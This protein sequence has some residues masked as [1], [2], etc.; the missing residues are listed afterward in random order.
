MIASRRSFLMGAAA[1]SAAVVTTET[2]RAMAAMQASA[3]WA[4]A[5]A[6]VEADIAPRAMRLVHGRAPAGL[7]GTLFRNGPAKFRRPGGSATHWFDGDGMM[8]AFRINE[9]QVTLDARFA[10]T[11]KRRWESE[12]G[13]VVTP[14]FGTSG[15]ARA[16]VGSND[17]ANAANT[18]VMV[19]GDEIWALWEGGSPLAMSAADLSTKRFVTLRDDL[20]GM[21]F[22]AHPRYD[23][24]GTIWNIGLNGDKAVVWRL[25]ADRSLHT[26]QVIDLPRASFMHDFTATARHLILVLQ[27]WVFDHR[28]MPYASQ[29][30][31]KPELGT[32]IMVV[33][34]A[35]LSRRRLFDLPAFSYFHVGDAWEDV[36]GTIRF[37]VAAGKD[38]AFAI[39]GAKV[40]VEQRGV[41]A[42]EPA[43]LKLVTLHADGRAELT[44]SGVIAEFPRSDPRRAGLRRRLTVHTAGER[45]DQ[46]LPSGIATWDWDSGRSDAFTFGATQIVEEAVFVPRGADESDAW[47]IAPSINLRQGV[48]ELHAFNA[49]RVADGPVATWRADVALPAGFHGVWA[50]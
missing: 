25:N 24:D 36:S 43:V 8:R 47:L 30:A 2:V 44:S 33:D 48:T 1:L 29:F 7:T 49:A 4:L 23:P 13:A 46:P 6:D 17:D 21:P 14:G 19:A 12:I 18:S 37:D 35:D 34:K 11:P 15:D 22:Q 26:A 38:V 41:V 20:K 40:L 32:Q 3:D 16:R 5:T 28:G 9:G 10:D 27:P 42:G 31:W 39:D 50:G 45:A